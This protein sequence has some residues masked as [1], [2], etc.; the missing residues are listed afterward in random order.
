[1]IDNY[2]PS[3]SQALRIGDIAEWK[4]ICV[5]SAAGMCA[6]LRHADPSREVVTLFDLQWNPDQDSL[7]SKIEEAV[8]DHPQVLDDF[9]AHIALV[10]PKCLLLP[11]DMVDDDDDMAAELYAEVYPS[12]PEDVMTDEAN[13][14]VYAYSLVPGLAAFLMRTFPG[15]SVKS[16]LA[17]LASRFKERS[18]DMP[19]VFVDIRHG[20]CDIL[21]FDCNRL[22]CAA[23]HQWAEQADIEY[24]V[25]NTMNVYGLVPEQTQVSLSGL[26][27]VKTPLMQSLRRTI[28]YVMLTM[29]PSIGARA[30][31]P[32]VA[33]MMMRR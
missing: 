8:Y 9:S 6:Y 5:I 14:I 29:V 17:V 30:G 3:G 18:S 33:S 21:A 11:A 4:L 13:G 23:T 2:D 27:D 24:H 22:L 10:A 25:F 16:H 12:E 32:V 31:M 1:M 20:E 7:L 19:R 15:A 26:R 28:N